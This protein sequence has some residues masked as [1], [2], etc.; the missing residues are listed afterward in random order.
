MVNG[1]GNKKW[2]VSDLTQILTNEKYMGDAISQKTFT[3]DFLN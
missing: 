3:V 2:N 1:A